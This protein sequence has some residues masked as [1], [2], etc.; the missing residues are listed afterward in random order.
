MRVSRYRGDS[1]GDSII[2]GELPT[3][4]EDL[5]FPIEAFGKGGGCFPLLELY[6][7]ESL[8]LAAEGLGA[9]KL[10]NEGFFHGYPSLTRHEVRHHNF[11]GQL[12][13]TGG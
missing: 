10:E 4:D 9:T 11:L 12:T 2:H 8:L 1:S 3:G 5:G 13:K 7:H 6:S